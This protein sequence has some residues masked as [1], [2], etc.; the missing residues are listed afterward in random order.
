MYH[1]EKATYFHVT[2]DTLSTDK[3]FRPEDEKVYAHDKQEF[4]ESEMEKKSDPISEEEFV[5]EQ[6]KNNEG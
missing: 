4:R 2:H 1:A 3:K 5:S 6:D